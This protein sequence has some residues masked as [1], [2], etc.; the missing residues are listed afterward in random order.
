[1]PSEYKKNQKSQTIDSETRNNFFVN[2]GPSFA[3]K[4]EKP[5]DGN[6]INQAIDS[7]GMKPV[8][9]DEVRFEKKQLVG[10]R[11]LKQ[12]IVL[13]RKFTKNCNIQPTKKGGGGVAL[14]ASK[15]YDLTTTKTS[16]NNDL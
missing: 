15:E 1:M 16:A 5:Y 12:P 14:L 4:I 2:I 3:K 11:L 13:Q 6:T 9:N 10:K 8:Q 7:F